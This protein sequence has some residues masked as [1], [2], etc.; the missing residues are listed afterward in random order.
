MKAWV[1]LT[2]ALNS[3]NRS[4]GLMDSYPFVLSDDAIEKLRFVHDVI[5]HAQAGEVVQR[6]VAAR[7]N[8]RLGTVAAN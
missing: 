2:L 3:L 8:E 6:K 5:K 7:W 1:P 4:M